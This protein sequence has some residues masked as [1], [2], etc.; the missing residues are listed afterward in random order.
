TGRKFFLQTPQDD[1]EFG[2]NTLG[3]QWQWMANPQA[4][5]YFM[6]PSKGILRLYSVLLPDSAR[7]LWEAPNVLLQKFP[8]EEFMVTTKLSFH[9]NPKLQNERAGLVI[10]G[11]SYAGLVIRSGTDGNYLEY[12]QCMDA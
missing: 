4:S 3:L 8:A 5:W 12:N 11:F 1:D 2:E 10:M 7:N 9:S 6:N